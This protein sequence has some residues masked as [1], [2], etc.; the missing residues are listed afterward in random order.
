MDDLFINLM[1]E[2]RHLHN[3]D[4]NT[5]IAKNKNADK[6]A[7]KYDYYDKKGHKKDRY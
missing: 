2:S 1:D 3:I 7:L 5:L 4:E 6:S